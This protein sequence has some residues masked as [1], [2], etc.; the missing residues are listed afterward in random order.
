MTDATHPCPKTGCT[1]RVNRN[2]L[3]CRTHWALVSTATQREVYA[4]YRSRRKDLMRHVR[5]VQQA[6]EEMNA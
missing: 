5:A 1:L 3:A 2:L 6:V 4:A